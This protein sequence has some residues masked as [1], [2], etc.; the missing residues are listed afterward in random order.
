M[1]NLVTILFIFIIVASC[2]TKEE[3]AFQY[4]DVSGVDVDVEVTRLDQQVQQ[5]S[6]VQE[7]DSFLRNNPVF[8]QVFLK[9][10]QY[11]SRRIIVNRFHEMI[12][13][14]NID[15]LYM[16]VNRIYDDLTPLERKLEMSF[17][18]IKHHFRA[19][20][21]PRVKTVL[22]GILHDLY[23]S[24]SLIM[25]GLD[26][27]LGA[28]GKY[29]PMDLPGYIKKRYQKEYILPQVL[30]LISTKYNANNQ[31]DQTALADMIFYGKSYYFTKM[32]MPGVSDTLIT[33]YTGEEHKEIHKFEHVI[34]AGLL[35]NEALYETSH[36][37]KQKFLSERP[38]TFEIGQNCPGRI[39]RWV[40]YRIV[41]E[42]M[43]KNPEITLSELMA[44]A[45][46]QQIFNDS[47]YRPSPP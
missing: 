35:E 22:S 30:M 41:Q 37:I 23:V 20:D 42:Y 8:E 36:I 18:H 26:Y 25:I 17:K 1:K 15:S 31:S 19:F 39:G 46:A 12:N 10:D 28:E 38:K 7:T 44:N 33:G 5:L 21:I 27:Y 43:Q 3:H 40:G 13:D 11:P 45:D 32:A 24:D 47:K 14:P 9:G 29:H 2:D 16:E 6:T 4:P 34:W